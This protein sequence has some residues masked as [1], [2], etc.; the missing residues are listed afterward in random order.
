MNLKKT[1]LLATIVAASIGTANTVNAATA[2]AVWT[3]TVPSN[4]PDSVVIT[5]QGGSTGDLIGMIIA[6]KDGTF[7]SDPVV[8]EARENT[9]EPEQPAKP[10]D[11]VNAQWTVKDAV[12]RYDNKIITEAKTV[13]RIDGLDVGVG[14][15][16]GQSQVIS[17]QIVQ[18]QP[19]ELAEIENADIRASLTMMATQI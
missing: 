15:D 10:G 18:T 3:G 16:A 8:M 11:L 4:T 2:T 12:I 7:E 13:V 5:G 19:L 1:A 14:G 17:A 9:A 6:E